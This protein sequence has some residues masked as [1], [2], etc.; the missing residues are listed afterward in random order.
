MGE[1]EKAIDL[2]KKRLK[3]N[4]ENT[5]SIL[6]LANLEKVKE[7]DESIKILEEIYAKEPRNVFDERS[8]TG[9]CFRSAKFMRMLANTV[10]QWKHWFVPIPHAM[11]F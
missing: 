2:H 6:G 11:I 9:L 1:K 4:A 3:D 10:N 5:R 7:N 8:K